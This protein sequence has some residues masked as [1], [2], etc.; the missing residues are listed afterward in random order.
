MRK[1]LKK[2]ADYADYVVFGVGMVAVVYTA[3]AINMWRC[4]N[5]K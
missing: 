5:E 3:A 1:K 4:R 2:I